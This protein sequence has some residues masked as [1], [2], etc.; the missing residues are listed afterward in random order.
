MKTTWNQYIQS[1]V[2]ALKDH[3]V[4]FGT[5]FEA[6]QCLLEQTLG[7]VLTLS[8]ILLI[9]WPPLPLITISLEH[10]REPL[11]GNFFTPRVFA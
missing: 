2:S 8:E 7:K 6:I 1:T 4:M 10:A 9:R 5:I 3:H 11:L